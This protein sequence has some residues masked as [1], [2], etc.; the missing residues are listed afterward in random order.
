MVPRK[1]DVAHIVNK[2]GN[3]CGIPSREAIASIEKEFES[4]YNVYLQKNI[5]WD[6]VSE[7]IRH[8][9]YD[10]LSLEKATEQIMQECFIPIAQD[11]DDAW[12]SLKQLDIFGTTYKP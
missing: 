11:V 2:Y 5:C 10:R 7:T 4:E 12:A 3:C 6:I 9:R 8:L 1:E